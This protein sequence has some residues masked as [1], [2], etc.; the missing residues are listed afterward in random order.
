MSRYYVNVVAEL[1]PA[2]QAGQYLP[3]GFRMVGVRTLPASPGPNGPGRI[4][5]VEVEDDEADDYYAGK[6]VDLVISRSGGRLNEHEPVRP[7]ETW[8]S[9]RTVIRDAP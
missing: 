2:F 6:V 7:M 5:L 8:I 4:A 1:L 9:A 3:A